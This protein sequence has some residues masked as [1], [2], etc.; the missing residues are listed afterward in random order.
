MTTPSTATASP[1]TIYV[2]VWETVAVTP[3]PPGWRNVY[4]ENGEVRAYLCPAV[5][6]QENRGK[7]AVWDDSFEPAEPPYETRAVF[8]AWTDSYL[9]PA[10][11]MGYEGTISPGQE[12]ADVLLE[13]SS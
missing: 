10:D 6:L 7:V 5:L 12:P 3:L 8:A 4:R 2:T 1:R 13:A 11:V 9:E